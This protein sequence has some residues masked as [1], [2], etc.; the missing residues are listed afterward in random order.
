VK[1]L[2]LKVEIEVHVPDELPND[3]VELDFG[4]CCRDVHVIDS[5]DPYGEP[6]AGAKV[7]QFFITG[8]EVL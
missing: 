7:D 8:V 5:T 3:N 1:K 6:V 2:I 4:L